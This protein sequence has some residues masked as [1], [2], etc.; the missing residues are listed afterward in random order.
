MGINKMKYDRLV[1]TP[2]LLDTGSEMIGWS[3]RKHPNWFIAAESTLSEATCT[4]VVQPKSDKSQVIEHSIKWF[5]YTEN[6]SVQK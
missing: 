4:N 1:P 3:S 5:P 2:Y 6:F